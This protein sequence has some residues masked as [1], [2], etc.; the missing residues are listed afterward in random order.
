MQTRE[1]VREDITALLTDR[2]GQ[3]A[4]TKLIE[5]AK[6]TAKIEIYI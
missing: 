4:L 5:E 2:A 1:E 3:E 6:R